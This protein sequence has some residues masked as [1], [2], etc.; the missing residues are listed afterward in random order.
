MISFESVSHGVGNTKIF[1]NLTLC[2]KKNEKVLIL[3]KSGIGKT[4]LF[5]L[6]LGFEQPE[7]GIILVD[8]LHLVKEHIHQ[9]RQKIF[10]LSQDIDLMDDIVLRLLTIVWEFNFSKELPM[11]E[12]NRHLIFLE[13][14]PDILRKR[15]REL[16]G[17]ERQRMGLLM[18][19]LLDRPIWLLDEPTSALDDAM[20]EKIATHIL[21]LDKTMII[22]S[23]D[24]CWQNNS[25]VR[26]EGWS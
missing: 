23:H 9:I 21:S 24:H 5:R 11:E 13:L 17:G 14:S 22:I 3:G 16:S 20:K 6:I 15:T 26:I 2:V 25:I 1:S 8:G 4:S 7:S 10:Y 19:F 18:G 12:V